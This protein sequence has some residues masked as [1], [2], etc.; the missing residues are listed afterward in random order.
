MCIEIHRGEIGDLQPK[1]RS[2]S[3]QAKQSFYLSLRLD[4]KVPPRGNN[5]TFSENTQS[6]VV[7][8]IIANPHSMSMGVFHNLTHIKKGWV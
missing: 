6:K 2:L 8:V 4:F 7:R 5:L 1:F 3:R